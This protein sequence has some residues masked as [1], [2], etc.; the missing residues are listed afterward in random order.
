MNS[1]G[2]KPKAGNFIL[3]QSKTKKGPNSPDFWARVEVSD[4]TLRGLVAIAKSGHSPE[5]S[6]TCWKK[7]GEYG[8]FLSGVLEVA[9]S[10]EGPARPQA[11][12]APPRNAR[13]APVQEPSAIDDEYN[14]DIDGIF[15]EKS[16]E[17]PW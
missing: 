15:G 8:P 1:T 16:D 6:I 5:L 10:Q 2:K 11:R 12:S 14:D 9:R 13:R 3:R 4:E 7:N 17:S